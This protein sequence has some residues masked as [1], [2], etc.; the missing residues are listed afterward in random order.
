MDGH[1]HLFFVVLLEPFRCNKDGAVINKQYTTAAV[2]ISQY[3]EKHISECLFAVVQG[4]AC[5]MCPVY[6]PKGSLRALG[7]SVPQ[8]KH[9]Q[10]RLVQ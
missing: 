10:R 7:G 9:L 6:Q 5:G 4:W 1:L 3:G 8:K 2:I